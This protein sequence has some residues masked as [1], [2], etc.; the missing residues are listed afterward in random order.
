MIQ[1]FN[2]SITYKNGK[3]DVWEGGKVRKWGFNNTETMLY[4]GVGR[5]MEDMK[6]T[7]SFIW[8]A[9]D[10]IK[11]FKVEQIQNFETKA[12]RIAFIKANKN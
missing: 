5:E 4:V 12:E 8:I 9:R 6:C 1:R 10:E 11:E 3:T 2:V 7:E